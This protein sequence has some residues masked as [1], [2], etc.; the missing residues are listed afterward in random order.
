MASWATEIAIQL[1][2]NIKGK[3]FRIIFNMYKGIKSCVA[4]NGDQSSFFSSFRGIRQG[5]NLSPV[6]FALFL[7]DLETFLSD[8]NWWSGVNLE[9][10]YDDIFL[11]LKLCV[12]PLR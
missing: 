1:A 7:N 2:N 4:Y 10:K 5:E 3:L 6:S 8:R 9:F 11:Y 12:L